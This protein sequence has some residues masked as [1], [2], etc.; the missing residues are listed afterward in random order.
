MTGT[1]MSEGEDP[2]LEAALDRA[3]AAMAS[4]TIPRSLVAR[5]V[6]EIPRLPQ[7]PADERD[8]GV[9]AAQE[10]ATVRRRFTRWGGLGIAIAAS[11]GAILLFPHVEAPSVD[12]PTAP[13][14]A[15]APA[16]RTVLAVGPAQATAP[17]AAS[18]PHHPAVVARRAGKDAAAR[19][20]GRDA[21]TAE[22]A[23]D[24][25]FVDPVEARPP[26]PAEPGA[27]GER[28]AVTAPPATLRDTDGGNLGADDATAIPALPAGPRVQGGMGFSGMGDMAA[29]MPGGGAPGGRPYS[30]YSAKRIATAS[31][32]ARCA[33]RVASS[34]KAP[35]NELRASVTISP[36]ERS[37]ASAT[38][39]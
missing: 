28:V 15:A 5:M 18:A 11:I 7:N 19:L 10:R 8:P 4:P 34:R 35:S 36:A 25:P 6:A 31:I 3:L 13:L 37:S 38:A 1:G 9:T 20:L 33:A 29:P 17:A 2:A 12:K 21:R 24:A 39:R 32:S 16:A 22:D 23:D 27:D 14:A 26:L 30:R